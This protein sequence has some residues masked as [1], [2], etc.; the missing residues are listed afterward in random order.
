MRQLR[1]LLRGPAQRTRR[2]PRHRGFR[3]PGR[4]RRTTARSARR[5]L[6]HKEHGRLGLAAPLGAALSRSVAAAVAAA[7]LETWPPVVLVPVP[8]AR[9]ATRARGH[10]PLLR[11]A[12]RAAYV[13]RASGRPTAVVPL[14]AWAVRSPTRRASAPPHAAQPVRRTPGTCSAAARVHP[15][16]T[17]VVVDDLVTTGASLAEAAR[18]LRAAGLAPSPPPWSRR[19]RAGG[20]STV[21]V[22]RASVGSWHPPGSVVASGRRCGSRSRAPRQADASRRR[23]GPRKATLRRPITVRLRD[24]SCPAGGPDGRRPGRRGEWLLSPRAPQ[25]ADVG[26]K[27]RSAGRVSSDSGRHRI[28]RTSAGSHRRTDGR[29]RGRSWAYRLTTRGGMPAWT[30]SSRVGRSTCRSASADPSPNAGEGRALRPQDPARRC[31]GV[32]GAQP[33][34]RRP[35]AA[36]GADDRSRGP[37]VRAEAAADDKYAAL[38][39]ACSRLEAR[40]RKAADR[41]HDHHKRMDAVASDAALDGA[42]VDDAEAAAGLGGPGRRATERGRWSSARRRTRPSP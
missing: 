4:S 36:R 8:S 35:R 30:S 21:W 42:P 23:N 32:Q 1:R 24:K 14:L 3:P 31:R 12:G 11:T 29:H 22:L 2:A 20:R 34:A 18:A 7:G 19:R 16:V 40:L 37:V 15:G 27:T 41:R 5:L 39:V 26:S 9:A 38:D 28:A 6:A 13:L 33:T 25:Q 17:V 10:D